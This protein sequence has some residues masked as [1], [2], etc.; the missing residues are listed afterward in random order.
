MPGIS[1]QI[2]REGRHWRLKFQIDGQVEPSHVVGCREGCAP[3][4]A[5]LLAA[6]A[7][8]NAVEAS[9][10]TEAAHSPT[11]ITVSM[12]SGRVLTFRQAYGQLLH[13]EIP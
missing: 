1:I 11:L 9:P 5:G 2:T 10:E 13:S 6:E 4:I 7:N 12:P 3:F 8:E